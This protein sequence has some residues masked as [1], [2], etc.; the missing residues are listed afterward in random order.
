MS[1]CPQPYW[2]TL[3]SQTLVVPDVEPMPK[4]AW[5]QE[6]EASTIMCWPVL[7]PH[8][9][10]EPTFPGDVRENVSVVQSPIEATEM[11]TI[12]NPCSKYPCF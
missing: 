9:I 3:M 5:W 6:L 8:M 10:G 2:V 11:G 7:N 1:D 4:F 12:S